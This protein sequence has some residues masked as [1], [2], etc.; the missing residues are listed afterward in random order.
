M[1]LLLLLA[2]VLLLRSLPAATAA[3][4]AT[5][6]TTF[7]SFPF[8]DNRDYYHYYYELI[9]LLARYI[10]E[11]FGLACEH[12]VRLESTL[13]TCALSMRIIE[14]VV[15]QVRPGYDICTTALPMIAEQKARRMLLGAGGGTK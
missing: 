7:L 15:L 10:G 6:T 14:G 3:T 11:I 9:H 13:V 4:T 8:P 5:T 12:H 2:L 1:L